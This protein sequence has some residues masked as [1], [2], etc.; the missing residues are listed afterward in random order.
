MFEQRI[1]QYYKLQ[2]QLN[3]LSTLKLQTLLGQSKTWKGWGINHLIDF[4]D[5]KVFLKR[6]P[7]TDLEY[8]NQFC[9]KN[10]FDLPLCYQYG[11]GSAGFGVYRELLANIKASQWVL[12]EEMVHFPLMYHYRIVPKIFDSTELKPR[13]ESYYHYWNNHGQI[14]EYIKSRESSNYELLIFLEYI[15]H[16]LNTWLKNHQ[17]LSYSCY[18]QMKNITSFL[19]QNGIVHMDAHFGNIMSDGKDLYLT[20]FGLIL[21]KEFDLNQEESTFIETHQNYDF[22]EVL[23]CFS[24]ILLSAYKKLNQSVKRKMDQIAHIEQGLSSHKL[25]VKLM[26][27]LELPDFQKE[28]GLDQTLIQILLSHKNSIFYMDQFFINL[29]EDPKK[30]LKYDS[31]HPLN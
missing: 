4:G 23:V 1:D 12:K 11:V 2:L 30:S 20:D 15:P 27:H 25:L 17:S 7:L 8:N 9:T 28:L 31:S 29:R 26:N 5:N 19:Q 18:S 3:N 22:S 14:R 16:T 13:S 24:D 6:I 10:S 21:D